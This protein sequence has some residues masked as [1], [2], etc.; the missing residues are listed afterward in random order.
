MK[1]TVILA[2]MLSLFVGAV[3]AQETDRI[4][5][6]CGDA[7]CEV[8]EAQGLYADLNDISSSLEKVKSSAERCETDHCR[9]ARESAELRQGL[10][11]RAE[12]SGRAGEIEQMIESLETVK[13]YT[14]DDIRDGTRELE[15]G[16]TDRETVERVLGLEEE[17]MSQVDS[18]LKKVDITSKVAGAI[19]CPEERCGAGAEASVVCGD[20]V[21]RAEVCSDGVCET[22]A[23]F[24]PDGSCGVEVCSDGKC[25]EEVCQG[26]ECPVDS[27]ETPETSRPE[28][29]DAD[30][31]GDGISDLVEGIAEDDGTI[32]CW[33]R[34]CEVPAKA[35]LGEDESVYCWGNRCEPPAE[36][37]NGGPV[38]CWG[39]NCPA[40]LEEPEAPDPET[41]ED[42][43]SEADEEDEQFSDT[44]ESSEDVNPVNDPPTAGDEKR[45]PADSRISGLRRML[46]GLFG[47]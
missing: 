40:S 18:A 24:C 41:E 20:G 36:K 7:V 8:A 11:S 15:E 45:E 6:R 22:R 1:N 10:I 29:V 46:G 13:T 34:S 25:G 28:P 32:Y 4:Q 35:D 33:G 5:E 3:T 38:Y 21:C 9:S 17:I 30:S 42:I 2:V 31:D 26:D 47:R 39:N 43:E 16:E 27:A 19:E 12:E 37:S 23:K 14:K 44:E